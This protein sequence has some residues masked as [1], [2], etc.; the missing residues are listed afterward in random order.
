MSLRR[1]GELNVITKTKHTMKTRIA[2]FIVFIFTLLFSF[3][4]IGQEIKTLQPE[5]QTSRVE[6]VKTI[7]K[8]GVEYVLHTGMRGGRYIIRT[9]KVSGNVYKQY[10]KEN[11]I[12]KLLA[13][14]KIKS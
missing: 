14:A 3:G 13:E 7:T 2:Q 1:V 12:A 4:M 5:V 8:S 11:Q 6:D 10:L 9:A